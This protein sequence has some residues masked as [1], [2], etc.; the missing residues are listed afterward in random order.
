MSVN[1]EMLHWWLT[2]TNDATDAQLAYAEVELT[3]SKEFVPHSDNVPLRSHRLF[4]KSFSTRYRQAPFEALERVVQEIPPNTKQ[5]RLLLSPMTS[6]TY[7]KTRH[8][9]WRN[10]TFQTQDLEVVLKLIQKPSPWEVTLLLQDGHIQAANG[11]K[12]SIIS[13]TQL[14]SLQNTRTG[15]ARYLQW[16]NDHA[17]ILGVT[18]SHLIGPKVGFSRSEF[19]PGTVN[20]AN[21]P[22]LKRSRSPD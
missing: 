21:C 5:C 20:L 11:R 22:C 19:T 10:H 17:Y 14:K 12:I 15:L 6:S 4:N 8:Y 7:L 9:C 1:S 13:P 3:Y 16:R 2:A 18:D